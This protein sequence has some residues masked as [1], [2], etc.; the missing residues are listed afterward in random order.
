MK[1]T[2]TNLQEILQGAG[3]DSLRAREATTQI[4]ASMTAVLA[5][6]E[7]IELRG[8]GTLEPRERKAH[9]ARNPKTGETVD[10][11]ARR[12]VVFHPGKELKSIP[13][14]DQLPSISR[15]LPKNP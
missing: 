2:R 1:F 6:G 4:I 14:L 5:V 12:R 13:L 9:K 15:E 7:V 8:L 10:V 3:L 11:P